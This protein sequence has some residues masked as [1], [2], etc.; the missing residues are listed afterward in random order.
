MWLG[1]VAC[2][3]G[4]IRVEMVRLLRDL[5]ALPQTPGSHLAVAFG[6]TAAETC[7]AELLRCQDDYPR[8]EKENP[9]HL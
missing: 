1:T 7:W 5:C 8:D 9:T 4:P 6:A 2:R 3:C